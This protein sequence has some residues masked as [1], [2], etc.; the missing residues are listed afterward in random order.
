MPSTSQ[1]YPLSTPDGVAIPLEILRPHSYVKKSFTSGAA[2]AVV[3]VPGNV[4]IAIL[5]ADQD[6]LV[7]FGGTAA[8]PAD[9]TNV[10]SVIFVPQGVRVCVAP[11][12]DN[13]TVIGETASGS[14]RIQFV[15]KWAGL[16]VQ[17]QY[18]K[19]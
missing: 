7:C 3:A 16:A 10:A 2:S 6:C 8:V 1:R 11:T 15:D 4:E 19:R 17:T 14:L 18:Q 5:S 13:F 12:A 9:N